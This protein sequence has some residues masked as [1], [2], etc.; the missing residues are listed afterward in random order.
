MVRK[1]KEEA[2]E[3]YTALLD[4][5]EHEFCQKG[6]TQTTLSDVASAAGMTRGAIYWHFKDKKDLFQ[7]M[8]DR[9]FLPM[10]SL[11]NEIASVASIDPLDALRQMTVHMLIHVAS[12]PRQRIVFDILFH[13]CEKSNDMAFLLHEKEKRSECLKRVEGILREA[14]AQGKLA[15]ETDTF[16]AVQAIHAYLIGLIHEWLI[17][18]TAY[19]LE[20]HAQMM[21]DIFLTGLVA[22]PPLKTPAACQ[23]N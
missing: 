16:L 21:M 18:P 2:Q 11:L 14:V 5:A 3:T 20:R 1:T 6:V 17:D 4:A 13:R 15:P 7:A 10:Q 19:D 8:C 9:A 12:N 22:R 23:A